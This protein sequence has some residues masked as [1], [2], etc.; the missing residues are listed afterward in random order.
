MTGPDQ[1]VALLASGLLLGVSLLVW[2]IKTLYLLGGERRWS[3]KIAVVP[4]IVLAGLAAG[5]VFQPAGF[6]FARAERD[7]VA[8][9]MLR[10]DRPHPDSAAFVGI[11]VTLGSSARGD[12][13]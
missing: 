3:W 10:E 13:S 8:T 7:K 9:E 12:V 4:V 6:D 11:L 1:L 5:S 2:A